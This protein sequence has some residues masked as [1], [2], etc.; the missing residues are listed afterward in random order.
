[1]ARFKLREPHINTYTSGAAK[2]TYVYEYRIL[3]DNTSFISG[4]TE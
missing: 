4:Y 1:M 2:F 3:S